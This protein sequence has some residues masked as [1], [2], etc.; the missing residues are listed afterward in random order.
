MSPPRLPESSESTPLPSPSDQADLALTDLREKLSQ[1]P[2]SAPKKSLASLLG[3]TALLGLTGL[4]IFQGAAPAQATPAPLET[5]MVSESQLE[6]YVGETFNGLSN[7]LSFNRALFHL[8]FVTLQEALACW[9]FML[10]IS[11]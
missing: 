5:E 9:L 2:D 10:C 3:A 4:G 1:K 7:S 11:Q 8:D 6:F